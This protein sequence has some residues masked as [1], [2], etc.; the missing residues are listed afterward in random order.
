LLRIGDVING[1]YR[2][3]RLLG[4]GGMGAVYEAQHDMLGTRVA[5]K[6]LHP[7]LAVR[8][9]LVERFLQEARVSA[10]I[11]SPHVV[12]VT[13]IDRT[14][15]GHAYIVM[16]ILQGEPLS[17]VLERQRRCTIATAC[18]YARQ[19]LI[20]LEAAHAL[21]IVHRD[22]KPE[23]VFV[24]FV[25]SQPVVKLID[26]GIAKLRRAEGQKNL[27]MAGVLMGT[28]EYMA[29][30][31]ARSADQADARSDIY[32]IGVMLYEMLSGRR[33]ATG[34]DGRIVAAKVERG[35]IE[36]LLSAAPEVPPELA[37]LV[38]RAIAPRPEMRFGNATEMRIALE[39]VGK[40]KRPATGPMPAV[41]PGVALGPTAQFPMPPPQVAT[42]AASPNVSAAVAQAGALYAEANRE[43]TMQ[44][45]PVDAVMAATAARGPAGPSVRRGTEVGSPMTPIPPAYGA[46]GASPG[47][48]PSGAGYA[49]GYGQGYPGAG[50]MVPSMRAKKGNGALV[51]VFV[52]VP[53]LVA[54][55]V[56]AV[57][58]FN[59]PSG[60]VDPVNQVADSGHTPGVPDNSADQVTPPPTT[61]VSD[62]PPLGPPV[63]TGTLPTG[64]PPGPTA[65]P[66]RPQFDGGFPR[67]PDAGR[68]PTPF[69]AGPGLPTFPPLPT[70]FPTGFPSSFPPFAIPSEF[71]FPIPVNPPPR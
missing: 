9:N 31:Q 23:N 51:A 60:P 64:V 32:A 42:A 13:D 70:G 38:H 71:P 67:F 62:I 43:S 14:P 24:T 3:L 59:N 61:T 33:P 27:T 6:V 44:G 21:G 65:V 11:R 48:G 50:A 7:E 35:D 63:G 2:L 22:L 10:Q 18:E 28:A 57:Y 66:P 39:G 1:K 25:G 15:D 17:S 36:P 19:M 16:E 69:D 56:V 26:F 68:P 4:D 52:L 37:G 34:D 41:T 12:Q 46:Y 30:E 49:P 54:A 20:G 8:T 29:P 53:L 55:G 45:A 5:I 58:L 47:Y 40:V